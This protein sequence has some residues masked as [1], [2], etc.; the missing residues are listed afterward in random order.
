M[1]IPDRLTETL[2]PTI[3]NM[4]KKIVLSVQM[5]GVVYNRLS[6]LGFEIRQTT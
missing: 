1:V 5:G 3:K 6:D 2:I 4:F